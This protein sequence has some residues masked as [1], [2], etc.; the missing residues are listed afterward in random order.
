MTDTNVEEEFRC[1]HGVIFCRRYKGGG[2]QGSPM[3]EVC[4]RCRI[5]TVFGVGPAEMFKG[6]RVDDA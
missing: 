1:P 2:Y 3:E 6:G 4:M 5:K